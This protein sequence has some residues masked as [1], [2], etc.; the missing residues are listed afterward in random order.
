MI[1]EAIGTI[2]ENFIVEVTPTYLSYFMDV[3]FV[4]AVIII[5]FSIGHLHGRYCEHKENGKWRVL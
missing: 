3:C 4:V 2:I 5:I 1:A